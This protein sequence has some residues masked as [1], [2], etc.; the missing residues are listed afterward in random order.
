MP[1]IAL[2][3]LYLAPGATGGMEVYARALVPRLV[4]AWPEARFV[5]FAG[6]ELAAEWRARP[7]HRALR[8]V[9]LP[10]SSA[11]RV[12]RTVAEQTLLAGAIGRHDIDLVHSLANTTP[13]LAPAP[14]VLTVHDLIHRRFPEAHA[15]LLSHGV[16]LLVSLA[17]R[18]ARRIVAVSQATAG[19][20]RD[21][22]DVPA[23]KVDVVPSGPGV[24]PV[25]APTPEPELRAR[26]GLGD[27]PL[28]LSPSA[29]R[30]HKNLA[31]L[32]DAMRSVDATLVVPGY[33]TVFDGDLSARAGTA[34]VVFCGWV[35]AADL[36]GLYRA[37]TCVALP[38]LAEGFGLPVLE[39][40]RRGVPVAC[41]DATALPEVAGDAALLFDPLDTGAIA[42]ALQ[43]LVTDAGL[44]REL[45]AAGRARAERFSWDAAAAGTVATYRRVLA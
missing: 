3:L 2:D 22:L 33:P 39:A 1:R 7:W 40:M 21:L 18:R 43:R 15:G 16:E 17:A 44:R 28:V 9:E 34:R 37:A 29:R 25:G 36:E 41:A 26:L 6:Q 12:R 8:L 42:E 14:A 4:A 10:V 38:S 32:L 11:T 27:G 23:D 5:V 24:D 35:S 30:P 45:A 19:D 13:L 31:R 20:L